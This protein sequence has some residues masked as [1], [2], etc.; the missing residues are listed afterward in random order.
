MSWNGND[1]NKDPWGRNDGP[2]DIDEAINKFKERLNKI[3][4]GS[5]GGSGPG[6][7]KKNIFS[8][9]WDSKK[10]NLEDYVG[11]IMI[12]VLNEPGN[13]GEIASA[14]GNNKGNIINL[15]LTSRKKTFFEM[16]VDVKVKNLNHF[17]N[18]I[19]SIR[20]LDSVSSVN[21]VKGE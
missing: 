13:L 9:S 18:I 20:S 6:F 8:L 15:K 21:R 4:G 17:T 19:A 12:I 10:R 14:I 5:S 11:R 16:S 3:L 1:N 2:P 7:S